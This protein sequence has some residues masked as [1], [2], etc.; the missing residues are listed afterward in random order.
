MSKDDEPKVSERERALMA[1]FAET[2]RT[3]M[4]G[5]STQRALSPEELHAKLM[6]DLRGKH[7]DPKA[8]GLIDVV[9]GCTS[10]FTGATFDA[11]ITWPAATIDGKIVG[12]LPG[13]GTVTALRNYKEPAGVDKHTADGGLVPNGMKITEN[14][15]QGEEIADGYKQWRW[16]SFWQADLR[17]F[18]GKSLP[19]HVRKTSRAA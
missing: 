18:V 12:R 8:L 6:A 3:L 15:G 9:E 19:P 7:I 1:A 2:M 16:E 13:D 17:R 5:A 4:P 10:D 14:Y 11:E